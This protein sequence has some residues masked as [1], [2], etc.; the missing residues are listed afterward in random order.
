MAL[1]AAKEAALRRI[2]PQHDVQ[3]SG[4]V[5]DIFIV[6]LGRERSVQEA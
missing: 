1:D 4:V 2:F 6:C 3:L 5:E